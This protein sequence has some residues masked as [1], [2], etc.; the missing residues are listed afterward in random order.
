MY[1]P[2]ALRLLGITLLCAA[3]VHADDSLEPVS[4]PGDHS[5]HGRLVASAVSSGSSVSTAQER[6]E[7]EHF[8]SAR[9]YF[10][11]GR[12]ASLVSSAAEKPYVLL[13]EFEANGSR[14]KLDTGHYEDTWVSRTQWRREASFGNSRYV[15]IRNGDKV[16][17]LSE[18]REARL[19][20]F[21]LA[22]LE[23]IPAPRSFVESDWRIGR[24]TVNGT[25]AT[26]VLSG[27]ES[28]HG[29]LDPQ[30]AR[31]YW[32]DDSGLLLR[33]F[34]SG[35]EADW[36]NG[37]DFNGMKVARQIE[38]RKDGQFFMRI[39]ILQ[40]KPAVSVSPRTFEPKG[41]QWKRAASEDR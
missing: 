38:V 4:K 24:D 21:V 1:H 25:P 8:D 18:G 17:E 5:F 16:Y 29:K 9:T 36:S 39:H 26:R 40:I 3:L 32:F 6:A 13:A 22:T 23:P 11:R 41:G 14:G 20:Q 31:G 27:Y 2:C 35:R 15:R 12:K 10:E 34:L 33:T 28:P 19:L 7:A 37:E 30:D